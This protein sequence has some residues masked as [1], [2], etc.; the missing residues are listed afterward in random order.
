MGLGPG[1]ITAQ[2]G[3]QQPYWSLRLYKLLTA[4]QADHPAPVMLSPSID[5]L[6]ATHSSVGE[7]RIQGA[8]SVSLQES[9]CDTESVLVML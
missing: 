9:Q 1:I 5:P 6:A 3:R 8:D 7:D 4:S 2:P